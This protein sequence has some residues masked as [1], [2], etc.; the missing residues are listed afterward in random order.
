MESLGRRNVNN[1]LVRCRR[2]FSVMNWEVAV[3]SF[4]VRIM[5]LSH[6]PS[7]PEHLMSHARG[8]LVVEIPHTSNKAFPA[9]RGVLASSKHVVGNQLEA[10]KAP[11]LPPAKKPVCVF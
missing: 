6:F 11:D 3:L 2:D 10:S 1:S 9:N 5:L 7:T 4:L 8:V